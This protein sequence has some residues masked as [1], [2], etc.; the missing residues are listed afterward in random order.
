MPVGV[1][2]AVEPHHGHP[3]VL[4]QAPGGGGGVGVHGHG[5]SA[6]EAG[7]DVVGGVG[8]AGVEHEVAG[9]GPQLE[10]QESHRLLRP[11]GRQDLGLT[12]PLHAAAPRHPLDDGGP[13]LGRAH[14]GGVAG[15]VGR[16]GAQ[17]VPGEVGQDRGP[18]QDPGGAGGG[19]AGGSGCSGSGGGVH[20]P[21]V[22]PVST[23]GTG[24]EERNA[25]AGCGVRSA[26]A[27]YSHS[28][29]RTRIL[30]KGLRW[31]GPGGWSRFSVDGARPARPQPWRCWFCG[32]RAAGEPSP[33]SSKKSMLARV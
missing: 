20:R 1:A 13:H 28:A 12:Q 23:P 26:T 24:S 17:G 6:H 5:H 25:S 30:R 21:I 4:G 14:G 16:V 15:G 3:P 2:G 19:G 8:G 29:P 7:P 18:G 11:D 10:G 27:G 31:K 9:T 22:P 32:G 33:L